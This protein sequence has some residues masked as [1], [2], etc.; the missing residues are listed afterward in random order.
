[1]VHSPF[2]PPVCLARWHSSPRKHGASIRPNAK[3]AARKHLQAS[4]TLQPTSEHAV[5]L[6]VM[7]IRFWRRR[8][9]VH[10][11]LRRQAEGNKALERCNSTSAATRN[12]A[13]FNHRESLAGRCEVGRTILSPPEPPKGGKFILRPICGHYP[14]FVRVSEMSS[15]AALR[16]MHLR[17]LPVTIESARLKAQKNAARE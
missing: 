5:T 2:D 10:S 12:K 17:L 8:Q 3:R 4:Q 13:Q 11:S 1:M 6:F 9:F 15:S 7:F 14:G 16:E